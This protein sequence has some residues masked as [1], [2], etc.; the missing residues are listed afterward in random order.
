MRLT[1]VLRPGAVKNPDTG[2]YALEDFVAVPTIATH[3]AWNIMECMPPEDVAM[4]A[5]WYERAKRA[6]LTVQFQEVKAPTNLFAT[7]RKR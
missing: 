6:P 3:G 2:Q 5:R 7:K 4:L 1:T